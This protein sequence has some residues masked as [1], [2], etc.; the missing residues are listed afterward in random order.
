M[1]R[2]PPRST[3]FPYTTLFRSP[4]GCRRPR[5]QRAGGPWP[6]RR[7]P[8][9][10]AMPAPE[11]LDS[12]RQAGVLG[13]L[14][15]RIRREDGVRVVGG[16]PRETWIGVLEVGDAQLVAAALLVPEELTPPADLEV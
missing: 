6:R 15:R 16:L 10:E 14:E 13:L 1:I 8:S 5:A 7:S 11:R 9:R 2:R 4:R 3:L 12:V